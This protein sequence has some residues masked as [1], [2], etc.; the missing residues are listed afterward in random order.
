MT[1]KQLAPTPIKHHFIHFTRLN[2]VDWMFLALIILMLLLSVA[3]FFAEHLV[4]PAV[5]NYWDA[6]YI[7]VYTWATPGFGNLFPVT[8]IGRVYGIALV[9]T[10][11]VTW[12]LFVANLAAFF[13][14]RAK[15]AEGRSV[16][17]RLLELDE[18]TDAELL[19]LQQ[20]VLNIINKR[21]NGSQVSIK[22]KSKNW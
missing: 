2:G 3:F 9:M 7:A 15:S 5:K 12:G 13:T 11:I 6:L 18:L 1:K 21:L 19:D 8:T 20:D 22:I 16:R 10:G 14:V 17:Q 4:N